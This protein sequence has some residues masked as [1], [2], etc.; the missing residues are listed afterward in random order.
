MARVLSPPL[1]SRPCHAP[2]HSPAPSWSRPDLGHAQQEHHQHQPGETREPHAKLKPPINSDP[3]FAPVSQHHAVEMGF[4]NS[5]AAFHP[6][7][8]GTL[9]N[10]EGPGATRAMTLSLCAGTLPGGPQPSQAPVGE[11]VGSPAQWTS[12]PQWHFINAAQKSP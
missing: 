9:H 8:M 6:T 5:Y 1:L 10:H 7:F 3:S 11:R 2:T 4:S 12:V